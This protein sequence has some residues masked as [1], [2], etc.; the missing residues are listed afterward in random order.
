[1][2][3]ILGVFSG[4]GP[5]LESLGAAWASGRLRGELERPF[6]HFFEVILGAQVKE[7]P[8]EVV[9]IGSKWRILVDVDEKRS[10]HKLVGWFSVVGRAILESLGATWAASWGA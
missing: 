2:R 9:G 5:V 1:M 10:L 6:Q 8:G 7:R 3:T 4:L